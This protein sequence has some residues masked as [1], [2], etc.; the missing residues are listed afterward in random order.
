MFDDAWELPP[1]LGLRASDLGTFADQGFVAFPQ[2]PPPTVT[3]P[4][5]Y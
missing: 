3:S 1:R 2:P 4:P 5:A